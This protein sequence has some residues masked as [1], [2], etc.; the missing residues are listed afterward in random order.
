MS[1]SC[2]RCSSF[3]PYYKGGWCNYRSEETSPGGYCSSCDSDGA[4]PEYDSEKVCS[5]CRY[6]DSYTRGGWCDYHSCT[7]NSESYCSGFSY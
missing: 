3:D 5:S 7:T 2:A 1:G 4:H 6:Y